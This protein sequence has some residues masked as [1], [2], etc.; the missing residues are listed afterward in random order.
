MQSSSYPADL[1]DWWQKQALNHFHLRDPKAAALKLADR[2]QSLSDAFTRGRSPESFS[3]CYQTPLD[4]IAYGNFFFP[5]TYVRTR[6]ALEELIVF[7][8]WKP[9]ENRALRILDAGGGTGAALI[10]AVD[11]LAE[12]F[13]TLTFDPA[14]LDQS[15]TA[16]KFYRN[17]SRDKRK[18]HLFKTTVIQEDLTPP[19][20]GPVPPRERY[21]LVIVSFA[22]GEAFFD[23]LDPEIHQ[24]L[25]LMKAR[26]HKN[27]LLL[28][29][30]PALKETCE[31]LERLRDH[32]A[33]G[34]DWQIW[35]PCLHRQ[36]CPL[37]AAGKYWCHEVR[38]W[39]VPPM[40]NRIN[41]VLEHSI[42]DL[43]FSFLALGPSSPT[44]VIPATPE[45]ARLLGPAVKAHGRLLFSG[46]NA[47][48]KHA[49]YDLLKRNLDKPQLAKLN[50]LQRGNIVR[51]GALEKLGGTDQFRCTN[52]DNLQKLF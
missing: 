16:L 5:Q 39:Q 40:V 14:L 47:D 18:R 48:G 32:V 6:I 38:N 41:H 37:L 15:G 4:W 30:E 9:E 26:L 12:H 35:G 44:A 31:R 11:C 34:T 50:D 45:Y 51:F 3:A 25:D 28:I 8:G 21:D 33:S 2:T 19:A 27:G 22:L 52:P 43:K 7:R 23:K 1:E 13:N 24:W 42:W 49:E 17:L 46:C 10:S 29:L 20:P 36:K